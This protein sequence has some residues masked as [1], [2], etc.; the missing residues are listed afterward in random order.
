[1]SMPKS[2]AKARRL[3]KKRQ[4]KQ[5]VKKQRRQRRDESPVGSFLDHEPLAGSPVKMSEVLNDFIEPYLDEVDNTAEVRLL[6]SIGVA[7]WNIG[8]C[9]D[10][11]E[12]A[13]T[14]EDTVEKVVAGGRGRRAKNNARTFLVGLVERKRSHFAH[15]TRPICDYHVHEQDDGGWY[16]QVVSLL[17][18]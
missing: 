4:R 8:L 14:I 5:K 18:P 1:M 13:S 6:I 9:D 15:I 3:A 16:L 11:N 12:R 2:P 17:E 10:A 7:A